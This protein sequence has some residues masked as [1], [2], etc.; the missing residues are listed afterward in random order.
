MKKLPSKTNAIRPQN[1][2]SKNYKFV[3]NLLFLYQY[4]TAKTENQ[5][6]FCE[7][8]IFIC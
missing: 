7:N 8:R 6:F 2:I 1:R 4:T 5:Q 3:N